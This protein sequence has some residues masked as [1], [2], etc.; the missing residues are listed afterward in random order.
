MKRI[1]VLAAVLLACGLMPSH[2]RAVMP[3]DGAGGP[4]AFSERD[5]PNPA[6]VRR[7]RERD[8][9]VDELRR[10]QRLPAGRG[11]AAREAA[12]QAAIDRLK[13][14]ADDRVLVILVEFAGT[15]MFPW[16]AG[17]S[18]WDPLGRCERTEYDGVN[19]G[20]TNASA[21][22]AAKYGYAGTSNFTYSGPLHNQIP[23]PLSAEDASGETIWTEDFSPAFYSNIIFGAGWTF[24]YLR[25]DNSPVN[26]DF[27]GKSVRDYYLDFSGQAYEIAGD[28]VGWVQVTNSTWWYGADA[29]PGRRSGATSAASSG[30]IPGAGDSRQLVIDALEAV[31]AA[32]P[33]FDW[34]P[35]DTDSDG[36]I[37]RLWIIHAGYGEEDDQ[38][39]LNRTAYGEG[40]LWSHSWSLATPYEITP[41]VS[42]STY[43]M[44]PENC[45]IGV[46][47]HEY[48]HNLGAIDLYT[49]GDGNTSVG[50]WSLMSDDWT[51]F[52]LG[53]QP[54]AM[55]PL[56]L[57]QWGWLDPL[58]ISDTAQ[59]Y[60]VTLGQAS[61]FP[62]GPDVHRAVKIELPDQVEALPVQPRGQYQ[63]WGGA[64]FDA[65]ATMILSSSLAIPAAGASLRYDAAYDTEA[66]YDFFSVYVSTNNGAG[67]I[68]IASYDGTSAGYPAYRSWTNS[69]NAYSNKSVHLAFQYWTDYSVLGDGAFVDEV[70]VVSG[71]STLL[72]DNAETD[73]GYWQYTAPWARN[74][75]AR[76]TPHGY[77]LQWRNTSASGGYDSCLGGDAWRFGPVGS[78]LLV[79]YDNP[80]YSD[81]EIADYLA[82][83]P[84]FGP[85]GRLLVVDAHPAPYHDPWWLQQG[86][87]GEQANIASRCLMRDAPFTLSNTPAFWL[88]PAFIQAATGF[89]GR[90]A[91]SLFSDALGYYPGLEKAAMAGDTSRWMTAQWD[92]SVVIPCVSNYGPKATGYPGH[93]N[94]WY[95]VQERVTEGT[96]VFQQYTTNLVNGGTSAGGTGNP[97][98]SAPAYGW[99]VRLISDAGTQATVR[100]WNGSP[101]EAVCLRPAAGS[102][103][104][105]SCEA[106]AERTLSLQ[107]ASNLAAGS[108]AFAN[109]TNFPTA[110]N[111]TVRMDGALQFYRIG[112]Q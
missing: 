25:E 10:Q 101:V 11:L 65:N 3:R 4:V 111:V 47:A 52:P 2:T 81:N 92:A 110:S 99:N 27:S 104:A 53:F 7:I 88:E 58:V 72:Y 40:A 57:D 91:V 87:T 74:T 13:L 35:Y 44:M 61:G 23:R 95:I 105:V 96:T 12:L 93:S 79:W 49:Y 34:A 51:G 97:G 68:E 22:F 71:V 54:P 85:K 77:Y 17:V 37:D 82:D 109:V 14:A 21:F 8:R 29:V 6:E 89:P 84:S 20:N 16:T 59:V 15:N 66:G 9:L 56:H 108:G 38:I 112:I 98:A 64:D 5:Q 43:I 63:W 39:L 106:V 76:I 32:Y 62:G 70:R 28:V 55:D 48:A 60:T 41:G 107:A 24:S 50:F 90:P 86:Y 18:T 30:G 46:L 67:W 102:L 100:I 69:L 42:A 36:I 83:G 1:L 80:R 75:G 26:A 103:L 33:A 73:T 31:K 78:G 45:G 94:F 19:Y